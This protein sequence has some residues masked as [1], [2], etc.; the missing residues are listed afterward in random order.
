[1]GLN[2]LIFFD[3]FGDVLPYGVDATYASASGFLG[4]GMS[5]GGL[6]N[7]GSS[8]G[9]SGGGG[10]GGSTAGSSSSSS[11]GSTAGSSSSSSSGS[12]KGSNLT[13]QQQKEQQ[14]QGLLPPSI[15]SIAAFPSDINVLSEFNSDPRIVSNLLNGNNYTRND[16]NVW[17]A[18]HLGGLISLSAG[19]SSG[20]FGD[21]VDLEASIIVN[22]VV[23]DGG[24]L[25]ATVVVTFT[26]YFT[27]YRF[28]RFLL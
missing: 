28:I 1:V 9:G 14:Q 23:P 13:A 24:A 25:V 22:A 8:I 18:P 12:V 21:G 17:L 10:G 16:L 2:G 4:G 6:R 15:A 27:S 5:G 11:G 26:R 19:S 3:K 7:L 20:Q